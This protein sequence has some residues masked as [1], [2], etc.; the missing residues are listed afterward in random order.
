MNQHHDRFFA[1]CYDPL[2]PW[3]RSAVQALADLGLDDV[4]IARYF[5]VGADQIRR[6]RATQVQPRL[7]KVRLGRKHPKTRVCPW[8][9]E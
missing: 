2:G 8:R 9:L 7:A 6:I 5:R 4:E 3:P 1:E